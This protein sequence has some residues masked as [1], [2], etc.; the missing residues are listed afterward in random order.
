MK[1]SLPVLVH[2]YK[3]E[4]DKDDYRVSTLELELTGDVDRE[5]LRHAQNLQKEPTA[6]ERAEVHLVVLGDGGERRRIGVTF[7]GSK[8]KNF[9]FY[10]VAQRAWNA[11]DRLEA[12]IQ[13]TS[14]LVLEVETITE[15]TLY[16]DDDNDTDAPGGALRS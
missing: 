10:A 1:Q 12:L 2:A 11:H 4:L 15:N 5:H 9:H 13:T 14:E 16:G 8:T 3:V 6:R 7:K